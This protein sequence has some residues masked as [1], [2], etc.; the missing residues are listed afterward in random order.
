MINIQRSPRPEVLTRSSSVTAYRTRGV[1]KA[2]WE[3]QHE[4]C[5]YCERKIPEKGHSKAVEHF[6][7]KAT[8]AAKIN[9]WSNLLLACS[10]CNGKKAD[11]FPLKLTENS[12]EAKVL[13]VNQGPNDESMLIDPS[14][15][16]IDPED[17]ITFQVDDTQDDLGFVNTRN[18]SE[19]GRNT[20]DVIGLYDVFYTKR[21]RSHYWD[22]AST[23]IVLMRAKEE[24]NAVALTNAKTTF[25]MLMSS[26]TQFAAFAREFAKF[27]KLDQRFGIVIQQ[28]AEV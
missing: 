7:P 18:H 11:K 24:D 6:Y 5:C 26:K 10:Q 23:Y 2:L 28:G 15:E 19:V 14:V 25:N 3:M 16:A 8:Y 20:I 4:K 17:H 1:V 13:Y 22:I 27:K 21:R 12:A 9:D